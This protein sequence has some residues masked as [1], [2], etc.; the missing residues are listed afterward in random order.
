M[1]KSGKVELFL[2]SAEAEINRSRF[3][4]LERRKAEIEKSFG[5]SL[6]WDFKEG[7]KQ[8]Y[9]RSVF[10]TG[11]LEDNEKWSE[12][13]NDLIDRLIRLERALRNHIKELP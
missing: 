5:T 11:G 10:E 2:N 8:H 9:I 4:F 7:R 6:V 3:E 12:I 13:Q 1:K